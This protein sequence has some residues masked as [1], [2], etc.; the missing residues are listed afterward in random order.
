MTKVSIHVPLPSNLA[1]A[2]LDALLVAAGL[3][4]VS[5]AVWSIECPEGDGAPVLLVILPSPDNSED[6][7]EQ[8]VRSAVARGDR[9]VGVRFSHP[10][11]VPNSL[12]EYGAAVTGWSSAEVRTAVCGEPEWRDADGGTRADADLKRNRC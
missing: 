10:T 4:K 9:V 11:T 1:S 12:E 2:D 7:L 6:D 8:V 5:E 3:T